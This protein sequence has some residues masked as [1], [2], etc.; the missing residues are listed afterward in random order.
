MRTLLGPTL[1][2]F[3]DQGDTGSWTLRPPYGPGGFK[4]SLTEGHWLQSCFLAVRGSRWAVRRGASTSPVMFGRTVGRHTHNHSHE[5]RA[6]RAAS[7]QSQQVLAAS[8]KPCVEGNFGKTMFAH[9]IA[10]PD[11]ASL[12]MSRLRLVA[13]CDVCCPGFRCPARATTRPGPHGTCP[14]RRGTPWHSARPGQH[15]SLNLIVR[16]PP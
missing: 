15:A 13:D 12:R 7:Q 4:L 3:P 2:C 14:R 8:S 9:S 10:M 6:R 11:W 5:T 16:H 1:V